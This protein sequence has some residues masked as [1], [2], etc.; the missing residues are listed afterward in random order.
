M[1]CWFFNRNKSVTPITHS[2]QEGEIGYGYSPKCEKLW[3]AIE[4]DNLPEVQ[5][6]IETVALVNSLIC[7]Y[8]SDYGEGT[9]TPLNLSISLHR[10]NIAKFLLD[11]GAEI[12][13]YPREMFLEVPLLEAAECDNL[14]IAKLLLDR[15][16]N[17]NRRGYN[18]R[19]ETPLHGALE[20]SNLE[21]AELLIA[22][23]AEVN[24][25][26]ENSGMTP[27]HEAAV[28]GIE[29]NVKLL[30]NAGADVNARDKSDRTPLALA[31]ECDR[32]DIARIL[33]EH[34]GK[35]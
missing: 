3:K 28:N 21:M 20:E 24:A 34:G 2:T 15:G 32:P 17:V 16:A 31:L 12:D 18:T 35:V 1:T 14:E 27:L 6:L 19:G 8:D 13:L 29:A 30:L 26:R 4:D 25:T 5:R 33:T 10:N 11:Q 23:G 7:S 9:T 22:R